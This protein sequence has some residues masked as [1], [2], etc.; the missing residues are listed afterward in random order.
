VVEEAEPSEKAESI[1]TTIQKEHPEGQK[2]N[3]ICLEDVDESSCSLRIDDSNVNKEN[4]TSR[5][6]T[7]SNKLVNK[8]GDKFNII[9]S[10]I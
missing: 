2:N 9:L 6:N 8:V 1:L 5:I 4:R 3:K 7:K 10:F